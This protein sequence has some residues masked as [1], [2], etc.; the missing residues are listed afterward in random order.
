[1]LTDSEIETNEMNANKNNNVASGYKI[2]WI[3]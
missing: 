2:K 1:M 3:L